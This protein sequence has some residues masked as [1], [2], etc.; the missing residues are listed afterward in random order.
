MFVLQKQNRRMTHAKCIWMLSYEIVILSI[1]KID[2]V[3]WSRSLPLNT[4]AF[5][6][7][8]TCEIP[9]KPAKI[10]V[11]RVNATERNQILLWE[12]SLKCK[13][14]KEHKQTNKP[15]HQNYF[16]S[17]ISTIPSLECF[18][19]LCIIWG[20]VLTSCGRSILPYR[21]RT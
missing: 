4:Y 5:V 7:R 1:C 14:Q 11:K 17:G 2:S 9:Q 16:W 10:R 20:L 13:Q 6:K 12:N 18:L 15:V 19:F 3:L 8:A 21:P